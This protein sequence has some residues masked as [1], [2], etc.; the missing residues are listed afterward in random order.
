MISNNDAGDDDNQ[1]AESNVEK[2]SN[3]VFAIV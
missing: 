2:E 3:V 1:I